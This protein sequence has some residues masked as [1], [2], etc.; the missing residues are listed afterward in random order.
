MGLDYSANYGLGVKV[1]AIQGLSLQ[2]VNE[3]YGFIDKI[4]DGSKYEYFF[5]GWYDDKEQDLFLTIRESFSDGNY[6]LKAKVKEFK[7][8]LKTNKI[9][10]E[11]DVDIVGGLSVS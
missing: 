2:Q 9:E 7:K 10:Y 6:N 5:T 3:N 8:F 4:L 11:A 1:K